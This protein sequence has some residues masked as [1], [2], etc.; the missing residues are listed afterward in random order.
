MPPHAVEGLE[1]AVPLQSLYERGH[2]TD[3]Q[4]PSVRQFTNP[5]ATAP[6][7][8]LTSVPEAGWIVTRPRETLFNKTSHW[9][10]STSPWRSVN[11]NATTY[12]MSW[13]TVSGSSEVA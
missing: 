8:R 5:H 13:F 2:H 10:L 3:L 7:V 6:L 4:T 9:P 1:V 11:S 12:R